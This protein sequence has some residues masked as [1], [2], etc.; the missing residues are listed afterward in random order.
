MII[1]YSKMQTEA[2]N[3]VFAI[4][5]PKLSIKGLTFT[6]SY[7]DQIRVSERS[8]SI[9]VCFSAIVGAKLVSRDSNIKITRTALNRVDVDFDEDNGFW[10]LFLIGGGKIA[11]T[12]TVREREMALKLSDMF[13]DW[14]CGNTQRYI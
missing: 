13:M 14:I 7:Y 5:L 2:M 4:D 11:Y 10:N 9:D 3:C 8:L 6:D 1:T 12:L